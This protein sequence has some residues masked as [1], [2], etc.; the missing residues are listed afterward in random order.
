MEEKLDSPAMRSGQCLI[1]R[2]RWE[3]GKESFVN[4][5]DK[6][7]CSDDNADYLHETAGPLEPLN[8]DTFFLRLDSLSKAV[9]AL[10]ELRSAFVRQHPQYG[11]RLSDIS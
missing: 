1:R 2:C 3:A 7:Q 11:K 6:K 10:D 9:N 4:P 8:A 5:K